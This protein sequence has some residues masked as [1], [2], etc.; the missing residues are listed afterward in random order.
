MPY[1]IS[2][3]PFPFLFLLPTSKDGVTDVGR[4]V[5]WLK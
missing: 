1:A 3:S 4:C 2:F 5:T